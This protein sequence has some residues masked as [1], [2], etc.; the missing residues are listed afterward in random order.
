MAAEVVADELGL[1]LFVVD[2]STVVSKYIGET[3][4]NLEELFNAASVGNQVL[5][6]DEAD[7]LFGK[8]TEVSDARDRYANLE[9]SYLL[10]ALEAFEGLVVLATNLSKNI[11]QAF[12][13]RIDVAIDFPMPGNEQRLQLWEKSIPDAAPQSKNVDLAD[14]A[15]R[16]DLSGGSIR[17]A[18]LYAAFLAADD[19]RDIDQ[20]LLLA[21]I[22]REY[23]KLGRLRAGAGFGSDIPDA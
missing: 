20:D 21:A 11:D 12:L 8:R 16:F 19:S 9:I 6:F 13:R 3:E 22:G 7:S 15:D 2:L 4:K 1:D 23:Q 5:F 17:K 14:L 18:A 10:Q